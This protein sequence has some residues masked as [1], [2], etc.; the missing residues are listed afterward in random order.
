MFAVIKTGGKQYKVK[1]GDVLTLEKLPQEEGAEVSFG[2]VL[3]VSDGKTLQLGKPHLNKIKV[4]A[5]I[6]K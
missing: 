1:K 5:K 4:K 2:E 6:L 3:L